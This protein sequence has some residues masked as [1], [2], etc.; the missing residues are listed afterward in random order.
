MFKRVIGESIKFIYFFGLFMIVFSS[1]SHAYIDPS[2]VTYV[3]QGVAGIFIAIGAV[4]T[5]FRHKI[6]AAIRKWYFSLKNKKKK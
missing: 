2:T 1:Y 5:I 4:L 3:I 6:K